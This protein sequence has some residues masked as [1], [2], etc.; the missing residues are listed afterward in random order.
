VWRQQPVVLYGTQPGVVEFVLDVQPGFTVYRDH[1]EVEVVANR[2]ALIVGAA[3]LPPGIVKKVEGREEEPREQYD[4]DIVVR[5]PV[6]AKPGT[7]GLQTLFVRMQHQS[8]IAGHCYR[9]QEYIMAVHVPVRATP[10]A[11]AA[12]PAAVHPHGSDLPK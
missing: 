8:C 10:A 12:P 7:V 9:P 4:D 2:S 11:P 5:V 6:Q 3:D 1:L